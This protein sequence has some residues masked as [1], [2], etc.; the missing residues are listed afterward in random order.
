M[1]QYQTVRPWWKRA[2]DQFLAAS[3]AGAKVS[4]ELVAG[5]LASYAKHR[6]LYGLIRGAI[7][8]RNRHV[9][10]VQGRL[11]QSQY[12]DIGRTTG[13]ERNRR[14]GIQPV[15]SGPQRPFVTLGFKARV[16]G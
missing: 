5:E 3:S 9:D 7:R 4:G 14:G 15:T 6:T 13:N 10:A 2:Q 1:C 8:I 16:G 12:T 11:T